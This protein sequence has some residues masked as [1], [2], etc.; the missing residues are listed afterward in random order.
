MPANWGRAAAQTNSTEI[1]RSW[2]PGSVVWGLVAVL[3]IALSTYCR[4]SNAPEAFDHARHTFVHGNLLRSQEEAERGYQR[5]MNSSP[6]WAVK[7]K[8]LQAESLLWSGMSEQVLDV[9]SQQQTAGERKLDIVVPILT[10]RGVAHAHL[11][12]FSQAVQDIRRAET[13]CATSKEAVCVEVIR[14]NGVLAIERGQFA[15]AQRYFESTLELARSGGDRFLEATALLNLAAASL[16]QSHLDDAI[17]SSESAYRLAS[18]LQASEIVQSALGNLGWAY[19]Q[20]GDD[21]K[22]LQAFTKAAAGAVELGDKINRVRWLTATAYIYLDKRDYVT[23]KGSYSQALALAQSIGSKGDIL[24]ALMSLGVVNGRTGRFVEAIQYSD[25]AISMAQADH[26][27]LDELYPLL[28]K[29]QV[30]AQLH[31]YSNAAAIFR[32]V[33]RDPQSDA[34]LKWEAEY[35]LARLEQDT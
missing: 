24:N 28:V 33:A 4:S 22:S 17:D 16:G 5:F 20:L 34:S 2:C 25:Q 8:L 15:D 32:E 10:L 18:T 30:A 35:S 31:G 13:L 3:L 1:Q 29:G 6:E 19:Y 14:A 11:H 23:A 21:E 7:F 26:N 12:E 27:R 9:L